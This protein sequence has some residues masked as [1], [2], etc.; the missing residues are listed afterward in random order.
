MILK[1]RNEAS[2]VQKWRHGND[3]IGINFRGTVSPPASQDKI[4]YTEIHNLLLARRLRK[5]YRKHDSWFNPFLDAK[6]GWEVSLNATRFVDIQVL[7]DLF[8][9]RSMSCIGFW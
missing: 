7:R 2:R 8:V 6:S 5:D 1:R 3:I 4:S 9:H